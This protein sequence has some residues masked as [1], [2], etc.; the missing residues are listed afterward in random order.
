[1]SNNGDNDKSR[2]ANRD[3]YEEFFHLL[4]LQSEKGVWLAQ[5]DKPMPINIPIEQ[6]E[7]HLMKHSYLSDCNIAFVKMYGYEDP[8]EMIGARFPQL[9]DNAESAN[10]ENL[11]L[12][13]RSNYKIN[14]VETCEIGK[15][16]TQKYFLNDVIGVVE[17]GYLVRVWG[18][19][20]EITAERF[21]R[22]VL[23]RLT[24][25]QCEI[26]KLTAEG[27]TVKEIADKLGISTRTVESL[28]KCIKDTFELESI[29]QLIAFAV[30]NGIHTLQN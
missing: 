26:L 17:D 15:N 12:F 20:E 16:I 30:K 28:R 19:Q 21:R 29:P 24:P 9:F 8:K 27:K 18:L 6:Q 11:R 1:M 5:F 4:F 22:K 23:N 13:L 2:F 14:Q 3:K 10:L 25:Q 7:E